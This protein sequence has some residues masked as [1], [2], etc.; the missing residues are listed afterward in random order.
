MLTEFEP[1]DGAH[2]GS[3]WFCG[4]DPPMSPGTTGLSPPQKD[5]KGLGSVGVCAGVS[6]H[7][8]ARELHRRVDSLLMTGSE[9]SPTKEKWAKG[10]VGAGIQPSALGP[11]GPWVLCHPRVV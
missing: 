6:P 9:L 1:E 5:V 7:T 3:Y 10:P 11:S 4:P 2:R 8:C